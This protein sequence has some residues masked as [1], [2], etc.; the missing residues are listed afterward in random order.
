MEIGLSHY[1]T[2]SAILFCLGIAVLV[3]RRNAIAILVGLELMLN[4]AGINFVA[5]SRYVTGNLEGQVVTIF[6]IILAAAEVAIALGIVLN[7]YNYLSTA[8]IDE[9]DSLRN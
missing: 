7:V 3:A 5:F 8:N 9:A 6:V 2:L 4:A 1:L